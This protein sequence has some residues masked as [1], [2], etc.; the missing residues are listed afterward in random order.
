MTNRVVKLTI[1]N[2]FTCPNCCIGQHELLT[3]VSHVKDTLHLPLSFELQHMP[4]RL[5]SDACL[6]SDGRKVDKSTFYSNKL[7]KEKFITIEKTINKWAKEKGVPIS[8]RGVMSQSTRAHRLARKAYMMGGQKL[9]LPILSAIFKANLEEEKDIADVDVLAE[10]AE[11]VGMMSKDEATKFLMSDELEKEINEMCDKA[12]DMGI[13]GVPLIIIDGKWAV[14]GGQSADVFIQIFQ[15]LAAAG[16]HAAPPS[17]PP[18]V[19]ETTL[20]A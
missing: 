17:F 5:I 11:K 12:R 20:C 9:Q 18:P 13:K 15:K 8:F 3:A 10:L 19:I 14:S 6:P 16:A 1:I 7:G 4:F 2:D